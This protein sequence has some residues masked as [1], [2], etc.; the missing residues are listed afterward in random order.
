MASSSAGASAAWQ[1]RAAPPPNL[2]CVLP[3]PPGSSLACSGGE[4]AAT[5]A[6]AATGTPCSPAAAVA[7][8]AG[9]GTRAEAAARSTKRARS[10]GSNSA[11]LA[12]Q[13][14]TVSSRKR[15]QTPGA[16][17]ASARKTTKISRRSTKRDTRGRHVSGTPRRMAA[18][19]RLSASGQAPQRRPNFWSAW[20]THKYSCSL[21]FPSSGWQWGS[22]ARM[23]RQS[24]W[25]WGPAPLPSSFWRLNAQ[26]RLAMPCAWIC[27]RSF[28]SRHRR[29]ETVAKSLSW[30]TPSRAKAQRVIESSWGLN[31]GRIW[32]ASSPMCWKTASLGRAFAVA[33]PH[34]KLAM[35]TGFTAPVPAPRAKCSMILRR[36][37]DWCCCAVTRLHTSRERS[38]RGNSARLRVMWVHAELKRSSFATWVFAKAQSRFVS[39]KGL[40]VLRWGMAS[41]AMRP[42]TY[43]THR[44]GTWSVA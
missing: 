35:F 15:P 23:A 32:R 34:I 30:R 12:M 36:V 11:A 10:F 33:R 22:S 6:A 8:T 24:T 17:V 16:S 7:A 3:S 18:V 42:N 28:L 29:W 21:N 2:N 19:K 31:P 39:S 5:R 26:R 44:S 38:D 13:T 43:C 40:K 25:S 4:W 41:S 9:R 14:L 27:S 1:T 37:L 20:K